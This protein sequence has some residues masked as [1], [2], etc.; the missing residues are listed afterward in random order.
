MDAFL[1]H[2][3]LHLSPLF[4]PVFT[5]CFLVT[6]HFMTCS[7]VVTAITADRAQQH[8]FP[9]REDEEAYQILPLVDPRCRL[10]G[11]TQ[12]DPSKHT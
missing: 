9:N 11:F 10:Q 5:S 8:K 7:E 12:N 3:E 2:L 1:L 6:N 4:L